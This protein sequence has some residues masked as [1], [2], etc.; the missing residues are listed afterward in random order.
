VAKSGKRRTRATVGAFL[1]QRP[2]LRF[3]LGFLVLCVGA[4]YVVGATPWIE[5]TFFPWYLELNA[6]ASALILDV[7]QE[8]AANDGTILRTPRFQIDIRRGCD[9]I[10]PSVIFGA[11]LL[12][13]PAPWR[14]KLIGLFAGVALL[15]VLN[16]L[17][18]ITL[19][20]TGVHFPNAF[21]A[22]HLDVWQ[23]IFIVLALLLWVIWA[24]WASPARPAKPNAN[25]TS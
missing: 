17:R 1:R 25:A 3:V 8:D 22:M 16:L 20:Y 4:L 6:A 19:Y 9:A 12:A 14:R 2:F 13:F 18:I 21:Q 7:L 24:L 5:R 10:A 15:A 23:P 11:A